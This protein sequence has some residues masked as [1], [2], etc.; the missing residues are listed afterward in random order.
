MHDHELDLVD[1]V[2]RKAAAA[3][4]RDGGVPAEVARA[5]RS[6]RPDA[7]GAPG[8]LGLQRAV[9][10]AG[11]TDLVQRR[12][13]GCDSA[14]HD[15]GSG[16]EAVQ[17]EEQE[18]PV[19]SVLGSSGAPLDQATRKDM[20]SS[21]GHDFGDVQVH[22]GSAAAAS[23]KSI[24]AKAYTSGNHIVFDEGRYQPDT[25]DGRRTLAHELTHVVQQRQGPVDGTEAGGGI[26]VSHPSDRFEQE[27]EH[28]AE[29]V[30]SS[31]TP[32]PAAEHG[33]GAA[34]P[35]PMAATAAQRS[36][37]L[38]AGAA[39]QREGTPEVKPEEEKDE[40]VPAKA[41]DAAEKP[42]EKPAEKE[43]EKEEDVP[44]SK[45]DVQREGDEEQ[46]QDQEQS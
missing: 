31:P 25:S 9:G 5:A 37:D 42:A 27:A 2:A 14:D 21:L 34:G 7:A 35:E 17:K 16:P 1:P 30:V 24:Q 40:D 33:G 43:E 28:V 15:H 10:N 38:D 20:E 41:E 32:A 13:D 11:V 18:S 39:V 46:E 19:R 23:A 4:E 44:V 6:G 12:C 45:L 26:K 8:L 36:A 22:T 3:R 29:R